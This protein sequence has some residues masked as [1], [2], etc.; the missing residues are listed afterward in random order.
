[1]PATN[2]RHAAARVEY[3][4]RIVAS[5]RASWQ[6]KPVPGMTLL[7]W[8]ALLSDEAWQD[9]AEQAGEVHMPSPETQLEI[10]RQVALGEWT[11]A[12]ISDEAPAVRLVR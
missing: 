5:L 10:V 2:P 12:R 3:A 7:Q 8:A 11:D 4:R 1:M 6:V 9:V